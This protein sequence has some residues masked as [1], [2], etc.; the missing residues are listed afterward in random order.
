MALSWPA[1]RPKGDPVQPRG[2]GT[3][4]LLTSSDFADSPPDVGSPKGR[5]FPHGAVKERT[6]CRLRGAPPAHNNAPYS[7]ADR[8]RT[9]DMY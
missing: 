3:R 5:P 9:G 8:A 7:S 4:G 2:A 6:H 1:A